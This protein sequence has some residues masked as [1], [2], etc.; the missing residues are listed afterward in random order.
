[1]VSNRAAWLLLATIVSCNRREHAPATPPLDAGVDGATNDLASGLEPQARRIRLLA[2]LSTG[3][4]TS[5]RP[6]LRWSTARPLDGPSFVDLCADRNCAKP[7]SSSRVD[8]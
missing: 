3:T 5:R 8:G 1:M 6:T 2:P 4:V 7:L